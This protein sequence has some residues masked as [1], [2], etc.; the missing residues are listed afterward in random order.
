VTAGVIPAVPDAAGRPAGRPARR[1]LT[2]AVAGRVLLAAVLALGAAGALVSLTWPPG[3]DH[4]LYA[5]TGDVV[6]RGG[7]VYR[8]AWDMHGPLVAYLFAGA[9]LL[10]GH[11]F[12][13]VRL[14]DLAFAL[15]GAAAV[16]RIVAHTGPAPSRTAAWWAAGVLVLTY[17]SLGYNETAQ[18][19]GWVGFVAA[20][21]F[22]PVLLAPDRRRSLILAGVAVGLFTLVK[23]F[24]L[25]LSVVPAVAFV[26]G[27]LD[28]RHSAAGAASAS[29]ASGPLLT[30]LVTLAVA[31]AAPIVAML[32]YFAARGALDA[33]FEVHLRYT[34]R[35]YN[36]LTELAPR[37]RVHGLIDFLMDGKVV[38]VA[39]AAAAVGGVALWRRG[40]RS[41]FAA[42]AAWTAL[43]FGFVLLQNKFYY[44]HWIPVLP[45]LAV[46]AAFGLAA[47]ARRA[48]DAAVFAVA[49]LAVLVVHAGLR[50]VVYAARGAA[51]AAGRITPHA[52]L[53]SFDEG[54]TSHP[55]DREQV[56]DYLRR[57]SAPGDGVAVWGTDAGVPYL[58]DR[59]TPFRLAGWY[60]PVVV[61]QGSTMQRAY[62]AEYVRGLGER[63]PAFL[64]VNA[65][66]GRVNP[67]VDLARHPDIEA[68]VARDF[69]R[70]TVVGPFTLYRHRDAQAP[71]A[72]RD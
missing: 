21:A 16:W 28:R 13:G 57:H 56:A 52:Y 65:E 7:M 17:V 42:L 4:G 63:R 31:T 33:L 1:A 11:H 22:V 40:Q 8:D 34:T 26:G 12:W 54:N 51:L 29:P 41:T 10:F 43:A 37:S 5:W 55:L 14:L 6:A 60:W 72:G 35:V 61:S 69:V 59:P 15:A 49:T 50:P 67:R 53:A 62:A 36:D 58:A 47:V 19:D 45:P 20:M 70:D 27:M 38:P 23:P 71:G 39:L 24:Y 32:G 68:V 66:A 2:L 25:L 3:F 46:L 64:V 44:Y 30:G 18:P 9:Q 48:G